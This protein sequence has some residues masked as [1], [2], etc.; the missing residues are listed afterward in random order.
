MAPSGK[1]DVNVLVL[2]KLG[3]QTPVAAVGFQVAEGNA[4][5]F[6]HYVTQ[7]A[8]QDQ[9]PLSREEADLDGKDLAAD[10]GPRQT[11]RD[12]GP[13]LGQGFVVSPEGET[14]VGLHALFVD[15]EL[16]RFHGL[17]VGC[18]GQFPVLKKPADCLAQD[19][20]D[21]PF[22]TA[23]ARFGSVAVNDGLQ[24]FWREGDPMV[25][26]AVFL[27]LFSDYEPFGDL[28]L[29]KIGVARHFDDLHA[30]LKRPGNGVQ[31]VGCGDEQHV[32]Q[33][34]GYLEVVVV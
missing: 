23:Y 3:D 1:V 11:V 15:G 12:A 29:F 10:F 33:I 6:L 4:R 25:T 19:C 26:E 27:G 16:Q 32:G 30:V 24:G 18:D 5:R 31:A 34:V 21:L 20:G 9:F 22:K 2:R 13:G 28:L 8:G 7:A 14:Q 17:V